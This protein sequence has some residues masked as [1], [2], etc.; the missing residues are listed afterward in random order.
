M[1]TL[2]LQFIAVA[3]T[4]I[5]QQQG[6]KPL[7]DTAISYKRQ[8][9]MAASQSQDP[10][11][12]TGTLLG[13]SNLPVVASRDNRPKF[14]LFQHLPL[15]ARRMIWHEAMVMELPHRL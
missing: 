7:F 5:S 4:Q 3:G 2:R 13:N 15:E 11:T 1:F 10:V 14:E 9:N 12:T 8:V 6:T